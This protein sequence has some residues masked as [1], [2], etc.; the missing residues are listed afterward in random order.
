MSPLQLLCH[1]GDFIE[2]KQIL[3][4]VENKQHQLQ[5]GLNREIERNA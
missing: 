4:Y 2:N 3:L 5:A 1:A